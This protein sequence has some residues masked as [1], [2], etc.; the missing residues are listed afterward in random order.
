MCHTRIQGSCGREGCNDTGMTVGG[1]V[2]DK[3]V[4]CQRGIQCAIH[5]CT[6]PDMDEMCRTEK[7]CVFRGR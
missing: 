5:G 3:D 7:E 4:M 2:R 6:A 1:T